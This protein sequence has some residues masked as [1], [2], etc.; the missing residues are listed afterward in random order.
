MWWSL[1]IALVALL[2][3]VLAV[4]LAWRGPRSTQELVARIELLEIRA[5]QLGDLVTREQ[6]RALAADA[7]AAKLAK[8]HQRADLAEQAAAVIAEAQQPREA[9]PMSREQLK[10]ELRRRALNPWR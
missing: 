8:D 3:S 2:G 4:L 7:R 10:A 6:R 9:A 5:Q 1:S